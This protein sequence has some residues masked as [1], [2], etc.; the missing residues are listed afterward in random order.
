MIQVFVKFILEQMKLKCSNK[1]QIVYTF[2]HLPVMREQSNPPNYSSKGVK[3]IHL[4]LLHD[5]KQ[6]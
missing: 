5:Q 2:S 1:K 4:Y 6:K 3:E